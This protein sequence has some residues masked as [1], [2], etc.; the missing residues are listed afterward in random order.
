[1]SVGTIACRRI[2]GVGLR[3]RSLVLGM[4]G[5][6]SVGGIEGGRVGW[7]EAIV[8]WL[9]IWFEIAVMDSRRR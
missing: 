2:G 5:L 1:M 6:G 3:M 9:T 7:E 4:R 8:L